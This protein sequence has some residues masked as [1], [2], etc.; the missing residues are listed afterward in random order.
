MKRLSRMARRSSVPA[1]LLLVALGVW[2]DEPPSTTPTDQAV[3]AAAP[4]AVPAPAPADSTSAATGRKKILLLPIEYVAFQRSAGGITEAVPEW[5]E[6][7]KSNTAAVLQKLLGGD[8]RFEL[9]TLPE[10]NDEEK[11]TLR[12]H[13]ELFKVVSVDAFQMISFGGKAWQDKRAHFDYTLGPG[14]KFL[15]ERSGADAAFIFGGLQT[16]Q[17]GGSVFMQLLIAGL[18]GVYYPGG[19]SF[20]T[21]GS[22]NLD[23]GR[24]DWFNS[25]V[26]QDVFGAGGVD[27]RKP[28]SAEKTVTKLLSP[29][30]TSPLVGTK[31]L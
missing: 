9:V 5:T 2:A 19:G 14:L 22:V 21:F 30:P 15:K 4:V 29:Y 23:D 24:I 16:T 18:T 1:V 6:S 10:L 31:I 13:V 25:L 12:E 7:C 11:A 8:S 17:S 20:I 28:E 27:L 3:P 26:G